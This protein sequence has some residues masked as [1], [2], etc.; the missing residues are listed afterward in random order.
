[1][2]A[3]AAPIIET[4]SRVLHAYNSEPGTV[5]RTTDTN[6]YVTW[7]NPEALELPESINKTHLIVVED[8]PEVPA[9]GITALDHD[10]LTRTVHAIRP[11]WAPADIHHYI[12]KAAEK[13]LGSPIALT[14]TALT[15]AL[16]P[17]NRTGMVIMLN[18]QHWDAA[19]AWEATLSE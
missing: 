9:Y 18:G 4:G 19:R 3:H 13:G 15:V 12:T 10:T 16:D 11:A 7:D 2:A 14:H 8:V 1:M 17:V 6:A 5:T